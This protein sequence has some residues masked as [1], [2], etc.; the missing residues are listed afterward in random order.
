MD[1]YSTDADASTANPNN[2]FSG[3]PIV[4]SDTVKISKDIG[5]VPTEIKFTFATDLTLSSNTTYYFW[6][7]QPSGKFKVVKT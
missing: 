6:V 1:V 2:K 5:E 4:T 3:T 7:K